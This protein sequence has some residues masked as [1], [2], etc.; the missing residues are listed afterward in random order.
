MDFTRASR[1]ENLIGTYMYLSHLA[2]LI[3]P[4]APTDVILE[5]K[6]IKMN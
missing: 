6:Y 5:F 1:T 2:I 4:H 3:K